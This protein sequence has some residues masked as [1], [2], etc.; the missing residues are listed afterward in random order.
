MPI[1]TAYSVPDRNSRR[2]RANV[3]HRL[4]LY[5]LYRAASVTNVTRALATQIIGGPVR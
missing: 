2:Y 3:A 5:R 4:I 1:K